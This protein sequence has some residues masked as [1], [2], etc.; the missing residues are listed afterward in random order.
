M[1]VTLWNYY[2]ETQCTPTPRAMSFSPVLFLRSAICFP[3]RSYLI[4]F[5]SRELLKTHR[6]SLAFSLPRKQISKGSWK[7]RIVT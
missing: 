2:S 3:F 4:K 1:D 7:S 5:A 6:F